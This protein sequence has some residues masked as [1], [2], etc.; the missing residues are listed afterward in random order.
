M[1]IIQSTV[2][3]KTKDYHYT[4][5]VQS[6]R[7]ANG[8][9]SQKVIANISDWTPIQ[10]ANL[11][12]AL[13]AARQG[14]TVVVNANTPLP[15]AEVSLSLDYLDVAVAIEAF[16]Q[17]KLDLILDELLG[18]DDT[19]VRPAQVVAAL[20]A[21]RMVVPDSKLAATRWFPRTALPE[22]LDIP[23]TSF[24]NSRVH[25]TL[26]A[27]EKI[28]LELQHRVA[29]QC[30]G[31]DPFAALF[32]DSTDTFFV[33]Q[34]PGKATF[35]KTKEG[36]FER[37][38]GVLLLCN[39]RGE[40]LRWKV[41]EGRSADNILFRNTFAE[42]E[43]TNW[44][45]NVPIVVDRAMG[46]SADIRAMF[47]TG[48]HFVTALRATEFDSYS[49]LIPRTEIGALQLELNANENDKSDMLS[50]ARVALDYGFEKLHGDLFIRDL[51]VCEAGHLPD[52]ES[53]SIES[54]LHLEDG[55][56]NPQAA[57]RI[58]YRIQQQFDDGVFGNQAQ[59]GQHY[60]FTKNWAQRRLSLTRLPESVRQDIE[61]G[62]ANHIALNALSNLAG[63][64]REQQD[65]A[66]QQLKRKRPSPFRNKKS[67]AHAS[68]P[69][70]PSENPLVRQVLYFSPS[71]HLQKRRNLNC[72]IEE[73][74]AFARTLSQDVLARK[75]GWQL[76]KLEAE[77]SRLKLRKLFEFSVDTEGR[78]VLLER[79]DE[80]R[81]L[82]GRFG[83]CFLVAHPDIQQTPAQLVSLYRAKNQVEADFQ[84]IKSI[85]E[86]RPIHHRNDEKVTAHVT[87]CVLALWLIRTIDALLKK[88][89]TTAT[90]A[91]ETM[92][93]CRLSRID[94][95]A[96][97]YYTVT[98]P[99]REQRQ[100]LETMGLS[101]L[102]ERSAVAT[103]LSPR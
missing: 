16:K 81:Q 98:K 57:L 10:I 94:M 43:N 102:V 6:V 26:D 55:H 59:A 80:M 58:G 42:L 79:Q 40:P 87:L 84:T 99:T 91:L 72:R 56:E 47:A 3:T 95:E 65:A 77:L 38:V 19:S 18:V 32:L 92:S 63:L 101:H 27:L 51:G 64:P 86:L 2:R 7:N 103:Q 36:R 54:A 74:Y 68:Y 39:E 67:R 76:A 53:F 8:T 62:N 4:R 60:G 44:A 50:L 88:T 78:I 71:L 22:L 20:I 17:N 90:A 23:I 12:A 75:K 28:D 83:F 46:S 11:Q 9:P 49:R 35:G 31:K 37:K 70:K 34:G 66:Y 30:A 61:D 69:T 14:K 13:D 96:L 100:L 73:A 82:R 25:R 33:G 5:L 93:S 24:N 97:N 48:L 15:E 21:Q 85:L 52:D 1:H 89:G 45:R 29:R 41:V